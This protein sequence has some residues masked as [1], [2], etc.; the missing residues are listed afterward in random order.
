MK[1]KAWHKSEITIGI[2]TG[3]LAMVILGC[4]KVPEK[5][6]EPSLPI[7]MTLETTG[8]SATTAISGGKVLFTGSVA[9]TSRGVCWNREG[10]P[11]I[12]DAKTADGNGSGT[13]TSFIDG[14]EE[15][16]AYYVRAYAI[17]PVGIGYG[18][19]D[20]F[21]TSTIPT[22]ETSEVGD[23]TATS[24]ISGGKVVF[25]GGASVTSRGVCWSTAKNPTIS[26]SR[27]NDGKNTGSFKS[28]LTGLLPATVYYARAYATNSIG[29][30][31]GI[32]V[33]FTTH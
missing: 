5:L 23:I 17:N 4:E 20:F 11:T 1:K 33:S 24:V 18:S 9:I 6:P 27:T 28:V 13:F 14:L 8:I 3:L 32:Q 29:T 7:I 21:T 15:D 26:C 19:Q 30:G 12:D 31:Y 22:V 16:T 2:I 25:C 10:N